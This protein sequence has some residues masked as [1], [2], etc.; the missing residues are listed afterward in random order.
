M[1]ES[2]IF[3]NIS[4]IYLLNIN[5]SISIHKCQAHFLYLR[6]KTLNIRFP[7]RQSYS[8]NVTITSTNTTG[9]DKV[10]SM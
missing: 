7:H 10:R 1:D 9:K 6:S 4:G 8:Q 2:Y 3:S 5:K